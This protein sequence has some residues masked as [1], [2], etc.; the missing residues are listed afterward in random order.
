[1]DAALA[2]LSTEEIQA[3]ITNGFLIKRKVLD[4]K[5]CAAAR[6]R[7][8]AGNTSSHLRRDDPKTWINGIPEADRQSTP[9]GMNDRT[10][11]SGWRLRELSGDED[12][13]DLLPRRVFPW[14]EQL[15]GEGEVVTPEVSS[16]AADPDPRGSR[17]RGWPV[18]GGKE[19]RG[20][21][22]VL[23]QERTSASPSLAAAARRGAH[24]DPEP[25]HLVVSGYIDKVP[26]DGGGIAVF[27]G[28]HR[29]LYEAEP[30]SVDIARYSVL[31]PPDSD[32]GAAAFV[33]PQPP[34]LKD[35]L[36]D[37]EPVEFFG[38]E[39]DVILWHGRMFHS[40]TPNYSTPPQIRQMITY[41]AYRKSVYDR[42]YNGRYVKGPRP[43][44]PPSVGARYGLE[45]G[46]AVPPP[47]PRPEGP[48]LWDDWSEAVRTAAATTSE[49]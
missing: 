40:A 3:F 4:T 10:G 30:G 9:D 6:D 32:S 48:G 11:N 13:I 18:W 42:T 21:Y 43:S 19:L 22:C 26:K 33:L 34:G 2:A 27:P 7:L 17:L 20:V 14:F 23:P 15:L 28:S 12:M 41:D 38:D 37:I 29:L 47:D 44:P 5:L 31:H 24:I 25:V 16:S 39:G 45:P 36:A 46:A 35:A 49:V 8:W 1:M